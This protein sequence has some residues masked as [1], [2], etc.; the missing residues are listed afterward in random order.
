M[1]KQVR[2][3]GSGSGRLLVQPF[4]LPINAPRVKYF[5]STKKAMAMGPIATTTMAM[6]RVW[7]G[8]STLVSKPVLALEVRNSALRVMA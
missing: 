7:V 1:D 3:S 4:R 8:I 5:C 6:R 2:H